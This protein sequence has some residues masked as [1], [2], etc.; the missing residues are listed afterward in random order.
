MN[1]LGRST[2]VQHPAIFSSSSSSFSSLPTPPSVEG[3]GAN[4]SS[5]GKEAYAGVAV[6][7]NPQLVAPEGLHWD[8]ATAQ[9]SISSSSE[10]FGRVLC[11]TYQGGSDDWV[12][13]GG[14][15]PA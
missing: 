9:V 6:F 14:N 15:T 11:F 8:L 13:S 3:S 5:G 4:L 12:C 1:F 10:P 2:P 7:A